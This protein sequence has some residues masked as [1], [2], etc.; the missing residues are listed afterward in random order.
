M[1]YWSDR[2]PDHVAASQVLTEAVFNAACAGIAAE[3]EAWKPEW[4][5]YYFINDS[6]PP[7]F[8]VDVTEHYETKRARAGLPREPVP[9]AAPPVPWRRG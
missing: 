5:C 6:A 2:H 1:P 7:S 9:A 4:I 8:V 3:G